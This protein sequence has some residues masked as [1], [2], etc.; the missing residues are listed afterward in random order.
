[1]GAHTTTDD[2]TR[3]RV[4]AELDEWKA[5]G[6]DQPA[7]DLPRAQRRAGRRRRSTPRS[8]PRPTS[9]PARIRRGD[10]RRCRPVAAV[11]LRPRVR[12]GHAAVDQG[13]RRVRG[14]SRVLRRGGRSLTWHRPRSAR[15]LNMGLRKAM[16]D[17]P[18]VLIM[19]EDV[20]KLGGVFRIT[21]GLQK[22]FGEDRVI[23]TPLAESG[24]HRHRDRP[25]AARLPAG[26]RDPVRR[27]RLARR[28]TRSPRSWPRCTT[29]RRAG[30]GCRSSSGSRTAAASARSSTTPRARRRTSRTRRVCAWSPARTRS[31]RTS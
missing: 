17:D 9:S 1:M 22:D 20:G 6:P 21:D 16:E 11:V 19:G 25:G 30:C 5:E 29:A 2:P 4:A 10:A 26:V 13:P 3:Y 7:A 31:T 24:H 14:V 27:L 8:R 12:R 23:D 28:T 18:K 15:R